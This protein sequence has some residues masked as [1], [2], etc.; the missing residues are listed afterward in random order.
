MNAALPVLPMLELLA[1][2]PWQAMVPFV[3]IALS[4]FG[5]I[6]TIKE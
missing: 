3:A 4:V 5:Y 1:V 2:L 6:T